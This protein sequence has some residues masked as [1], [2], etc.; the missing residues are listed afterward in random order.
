M[1]ENTEDVKKTLFHRKKKEKVKRPWWVELLSWILT[2]A[3]ALAGALLIR[4][5]IFE[6]V[7]VDGASMNDTLAN[8]EVMFVDKTGY[9]SGWFCFPWQSNEQKEASAKFSYFGDPKRFDVVICR[10][11]D[12]GDTNFVKRVVG[13]PGDTVA[14]QDGYLSVNGERYEEPYINDD[15]RTGHYAQYSE[16]RVPAKDDVITFSDEQLFLVNGE[17]YAYG[18]TRVT[19]VCDKQVLKLRMIRTGISANFVAELDGQAVRYS[20]GVWYL[21]TEAQTGNPLAGKEFRVTD[22]YYFVMGDHRNNSND[23]RDQGAIPRTYIIGHVKQVVLPF[24][25]WRGVPNGLEVQ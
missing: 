4:T 2:L 24:S 11:P 3:A 13:T 7:K 22:N 18:P 17:S 21:G 8:G 9:G 19:A 1:S 5:F 12:R 23:S 25:G 15:Y 10:Y 20:D 6:P 16:V 14:I